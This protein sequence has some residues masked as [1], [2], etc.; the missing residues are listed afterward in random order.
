MKETAGSMITMDF[1]NLIYETTLPEEDVFVRIFVTAE[2]E[3]YILLHLGENI[4]EQ[5][6][7]L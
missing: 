5:M 1:L 2:N 4:F 7:L 6:W 3:A